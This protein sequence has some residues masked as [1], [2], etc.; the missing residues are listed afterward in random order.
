MFR[1][2]L[3][4]VLLASTPLLADEPPEWVD[5][6]DKDGIHV[7]YRDRVELGGREVKAETIVEA[8]PKQV[9][10]VLADVEKYT[11]FMPYLEK[12][13]VIETLEDGRIQYEVV[14]APV[15]SRRDYVLRITV[16]KPTA[17]SW[18]IDWKPAPEGKGPPATKKM[19]RI[20]VNEGWYLI[21]PHEKGTKLS[22]MLLTH[23]GGSIPNFIAKRSNTSAVPDLLDGIRKRVKDTTWKR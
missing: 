6:H 15:V 19:V 13:E 8:P 21:E 18:K 1:F 2:C 14:N 4:L 20:L 9:F 3:A 23:P 17:E 16:T 22:Y 10:D 12:M 11:E 7:W 5:A